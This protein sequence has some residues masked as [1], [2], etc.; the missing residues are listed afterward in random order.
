MGEE[1]GGEWM[2]RNFMGVEKRFVG[3]VEFF[4]ICLNIILPPTP[5]DVFKSMWERGEEKF[6][7]DGE[8]TFLG[9]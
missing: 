3:E 5:Y 8:E 9:G 1:R 4:E 2:G 6:G 7:G